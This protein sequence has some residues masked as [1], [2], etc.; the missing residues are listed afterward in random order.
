MILVAVER[1]WGERV[2]LLARHPPL[3][4]FVDERIAK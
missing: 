1:Q 4:D 2:N 3:N